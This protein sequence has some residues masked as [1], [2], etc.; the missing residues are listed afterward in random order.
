MMYFRLGLTRRRSALFFFLSICFIQFQSCGG[1]TGEQDGQGTLFTLLPSKTT[2]IEFNNALDENLYNDNNILSFDLYFNGAGV[3]LGDLDNNGLPDVFFT[4]NEVPNKLYL[5]KGGFE[6]EDISATAGINEHKLWAAGVTMADVNGDGWLD[7]YVCQAGASED[8]AQR[9]NLLFINNGTD[10]GELSF[11]EKAAEYGLNDGNKST[12]AAFFDYD[13]DGDL[14]CFVMNESKY[15]RVVYSAVFEALKDKNNLLEASSN[16]FRNDGGKFVKVTEEAG[17]LRYGF[18][19]G[20]SISDLNEDGWPDIYQAN[21]YSVAD[22]M[23]I[24]NGD[25]TFTDKMKEMTRH[26]V[27]SGM[28]CDIAD[29]NNDG[30]FDIAVLDMPPNDHVRNNTIMDIMDAE[31]FHYFVDQLGYPVQYMFNSL[32]L[33]NG[34]GTYSNIAGLAGVLR[35]DW[36]WAALLADLDQDGYK[37]YLVTNGYRRYAMDGDFKRSMEIRRKAHNGTV[38]NEYRKDLYEMMPEIKLSNVAYR[39]NHDLT[40]TDSAMS[41]GLGQPAWSYGAAYA[42]LDL[43]GDLDLVVNNIDDEAFVYR[44]NAVEQHRGNFFVVKLKGKLTACAKVTIHYG[45]AIQ[46]G[47]MMNTRG[48]ASAVEELVH[49]GLGQVEMVDSL[50]VL[51][52]GGRISKLQNVPANQTLVINDSSAMPYEKPVVPTAKTLFQRIDSEGIGLAF[53]HKENEFDD[54]SIEKLLPHKQSRPG[55]KIGVADVNKDGL[56]DFFIGGAAYQS[57]VLFL[58]NANATFSKAET[59]PWQIDALCEDMEPLFFDADNNSVP[60]LYLASG[61]GGEFQDD[62]GHLQDRLYVS[63][64]DGKYFKVGNALPEMLRSTNCAKAVDFD[65][66]GDIDLFVGGAAV[67]G[68]Y[69]YPG[70]SYILKNEHYK[71]L[72]VTGEVAP[73]LLSPGIVKDAIWTDLNNDTWPDL[74]VTGEWMPI[75]IFLNEKGVLRDASEQY[76]TAGL[77]GWWQS[78]AAS[79]VDG[80]GDLDLIAGN[81]GLNTKFLASADEPFHVFANDFDKNGTNDVVL[82]NYYKG[83]LVPTKGLEYSV[84]QMP[85]L[86]RKF[87]SYHDFANASLEEIY[88]KKDL[89]ESLHLQATTFESLILLNEGSSFTPETLPIEAQFAPI[90]GI[91]PYDFDSDGKMDLLVA[92]N[93]YD[94][95]VEI[96]R[97][98]AGNGLILMGRGDGRFIPLTIRQSGFFAPGNVKDVKLL[99]LAGGR[100]HL[101]LVANN[102]GPLE[103]FKFQGAG[104]PGVQ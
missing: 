28:G 62:A 21:D 80:D 90:N 2:H 57:G 71:F 33:N 43:D 3:A 101:V 97:H 100:E 77:T 16:L 8:P 98:D 39:N 36:S 99:T 89:G 76:G 27:Y 52:P 95:D 85:F 68:R 53:T 66:D 24:N 75:S 42:D 19:L 1:P 55:P 23:Y 46:S 6:F 5:N 31:A 102:D 51:W 94:T 41:W 18:G 30:L 82:A 104:M 84:M 45:G 54:Y 20:L 9:Q 73:A 59:Q 49:F 48:Y 86:E 69:P 72:D 15:Y 74:V 4:G 26:T 17:L 64:G 10:A 12:Q 58:Q 78:I 47:E 63:P 65:H 22:F 29:I 91:I 96:P 25:G 67:P 7:I 61:G 93:M 37:D 87:I 11:S 56:E 92:G 88:G 32:Q 38:P 79:D 35:T 50:E 60:D 81:V 103:V 70:R 83:K 34:N 14:D 44:N 13:K 40:F